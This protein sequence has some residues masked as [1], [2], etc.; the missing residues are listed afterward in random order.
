LAVHS[1]THGQVVDESYRFTGRHLSVYD[2]SKADAHALAERFMRDGLPL[3]IVQPGVIYGPGDTSLFLPTIRQYMARRLPVLPAGTAFCWSHVDDV[4]RAHRLAME[5][6][7]AGESYIIA[8]PCHP[9][10]EV[11]ETL[12]ELTGVPLPMR[13]PGRMLQG[14]SVLMRLVEALMPVPA[15]FSSEYLREN[16]G[17]T[18]IADSSKARRELGYEARPLK[19]GLKDVIASL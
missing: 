14:T 2:R 19:D 12:K 4:A 6:G 9:V 18:Y 3:A 5:T 17:T 13:V 10:T 11:F 15:V 1:D 8:G 7:R 16:G